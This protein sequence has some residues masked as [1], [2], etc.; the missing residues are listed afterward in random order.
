MENPSAL[1]FRE[2]M[3]RC[4]L[5]KQWGQG[6][7][8]EVLN[9]SA[10]VVSRWETGKKPVSIRKVG[11]LQNL[12]GM[13]EGICADYLIYRTGV[14]PYP[15]TYGSLAELTR[16]GYNQRELLDGAWDVYNQFPEPELPAHVEGSNDYGSADKWD[17]LQE[18]FPESFFCVISNRDSRVRAFLHIL[19]LTDE[20]YESGLLGK[21]I[22]KYLTLAECIGFLIPVRHNLYI[23]DVFVDQSYKDPVIHEILLNMFVSFLMSLERTGHGVRRM[24]ANASEYQA[25]NYCKALSFQHE[26]EHQE[27][28]MHDP[29]SENE[30]PPTQIWQLEFVKGTNSKLFELFPALR[31]LLC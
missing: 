3:R 6:Y 19:S 28:R 29:D 2:E 26:C 25:I 8:E 23:V 31:K 11:L 24:M 16:R 22:N 17:R 20:V 18:A 9:L 27:H 12:L 14:N 1:A 15:Y 10:G 13:N 7:L 21:N 30:Y 5:Q 4:R